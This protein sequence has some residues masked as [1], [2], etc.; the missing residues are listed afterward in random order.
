MD[1]AAAEMMSTRLAE[2][3]SFMKP[4]YEEQ[5][6]VSSSSTCGVR[7]ERDGESSPW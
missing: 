1:G 4:A 7:M 2:L 3:V 6:H 5:G